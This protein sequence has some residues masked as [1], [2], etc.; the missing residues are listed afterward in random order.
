MAKYVR[1]YYAVILS[2]D[3]SVRKEP[4]VPLLKFKWQ[5]FQFFVHKT[6]GLNPFWDYTATDAD[7]GLVVER[8][9]TL[10]KAKRAALKIL[11]FHGL[12]E[13]KEYK[14]MM[15]AMYNLGGI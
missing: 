4:L 8:G 2:R 5:G 12:G 15:I 6:Y 1:E 14:S 10:L 7:T 9:D 13:Y 11:N 3:G